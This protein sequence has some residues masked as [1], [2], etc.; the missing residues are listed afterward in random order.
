MALSFSWLCWLLLLSC[1]GTPE[2][3]DN[4]ILLTSDMVINEAGMGSAE[5]LV[6]EQQSFNTT[7]KTRWEPQAFIVLPLVAAVIDL[8]SEYELTNLRFYDGKSN[9]KIRFSY[10]K[11]FAWTTL[12]D[13]DLSDKGWQTQPCNKIITRYLRL[14]SLVPGKPNTA[15]PMP[16]E[17]ILQGTRQ[18]KLRPETTAKPMPL[19]TM[20][21]FTGTNG[22]IDDPVGILQ[23]T[24]VLREYH[25]WPGWNEPLKGK[26][27]FN[28]TVQG[29]N[30]DAYYT[31]LKN[32]GISVC[33]AIQLSPLW[34]TQGRDEDAKPVPP[35]ADPANPES[36]AEHAS[37]F[38][39]YAARY[40]YG[41]VTDSQLK[42]AAGQPRSRNLGLLTQYENWN[43]PDKTWKEQS[44]YFTPYQYAAMSSADYDG[45]LGSL[46]GDYGIKNADPAAKLVMAG[47]STADLNY[48]PAVKFWCDHYRKGD[49]PFAAINFHH[50][51]NDGKSNFDSKQGV[52]PE[53]HKLKE[54]M[55]GIVAYRNK[56][57]PGV[58]VWVTEFGYD[59]YGKSP[60]HSP[61]I[62]SMDLLEV[63]AI[64]NIRT[65]LA[66]AAAGIDRAT[67]F[68]I[69]DGEPF[70]TTYNSAGA[71][72]NIQVKGEWVRNRR[73]AWYYIHTFKTRLTGMRFDKEVPSGN[74]KV[75]VYKFKHATNP[76]LK[77]YAVW[78][79]T[80]NDEKVSDFLLKLEADET[81]AQ[82]IDLIDKAPEG[83]ATDLTVQS[84]SL[85]LSVSEKP[86]LVIVGS[87][88]LIS[89]FVTEQK[90]VLTPKMVTNEGI[91]NAE[92]LVDE[93]DLIGDPN[94]GNTPAKPDKGWNVDYSKDYELSAF[95]DLGKVYDVSKVFINDG[96]GEGLLTISAG[97]P[98]KWTPVA[99]DPLKG[100]QSW[101]SHVLNT[102]TRYLRFTRGSKNAG[103]FEIAVYV[104]Q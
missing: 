81:K 93:Q 35:G 102:K 84:K 63:N 87:G 58:Q 9:G 30:F 68:M 85:T 70:T 51:C 47:V 16:H 54:R 80:S 43:E 15:P 100:Y 26:I 99:T 50:Y 69:R 76:K 7:P 77:A 88:E 90:L 49:F 66:L 36:Y 18:G 65:F 5:M 1:G 53:D 40:G 83:K 19:P 104:K 17:I 52:S 91:D 92:G 24:D 96:T 11:P 39:Q 33:P 41:K 72:N 3:V 14:E 89:N 79:K 22:F 23:M 64:W 67:Q 62:G 57:L 2:P 48:V 20:D 42:L 71:T 13:H 55:Q 94:S 56:Y 44:G 45:H 28:P 10:G 31:N 95:I 27:A 98:G 6:D 4:Q 78:C 60:Q 32:A 73:P 8:G 21:K 37:F 75:L 46:K 101:N 38:F 74:D 82:R 29:W 61:P 59:L 103:V 86:V 97:S 25:I 12:A 34:L